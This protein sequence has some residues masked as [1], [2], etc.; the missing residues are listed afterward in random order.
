PVVIQLPIGVESSFAGVIDLIAM[1]A[2]IWET[3]SL[4]A[5]FNIVDIPPELASQAA[6]WRH[7]LIE[8]AVE[9]DDAA[10][11]AY[12]EGHE[13]DAATIKRCIRK[14]TISS[15]FVPV[16]CGSAFKNKGVQPLL[17][18]VI[19]FL[20]SPADIPSVKGTSV[21]GKEAMERPASDEAPFSGLA[22][23]IMT[24]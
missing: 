10:L 2:I 5:K 13:P 8:T 14:G 1:K 15:V 24:D 3:E 18:A 17:D 16:L 19:D 9:Q 20:P 7:K 21:N 12:L 6:E 23:K 22:F 4:G 11:S